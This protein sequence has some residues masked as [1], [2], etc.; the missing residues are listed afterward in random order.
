VSSVKKKQGTSLFEPSIKCILLVTKK[1]QK[2]RID[3]GAM[4]RDVGG[5]GWMNDGAALAGPFGE[6]LEQ[7]G[8]PQTRRVGFLNVKAKRVTTPW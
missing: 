3:W 5:G 1:N 8:G 6:F 2:V 4:R 7:G